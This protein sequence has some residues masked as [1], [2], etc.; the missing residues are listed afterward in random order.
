MEE[1]D[2]KRKIKHKEIWSKSIVGK[3]VSEI[4][5]KTVV[6][7]RVKKRAPVLGPVSSLAWS[8]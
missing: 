1:P 3:N 2:A 4:K 5:G 8:R 6:N 7:L